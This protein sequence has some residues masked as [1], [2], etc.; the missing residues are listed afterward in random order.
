MIGTW[1]M[2]GEKMICRI[3]HG[4]TKPENADTYENLLKKEIFPEIA[5]KNVSGYRGIYLLRREIT[6]EVEFITIM[7][8]DS[9]EAVKQFAGEDY[10][11]SYVPDKARLVLSR[12]DD[13]SQ[14]YE[15]KESI[16][17]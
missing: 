12:H 17:Y 2:K 7:H 6:N 10:E 5:S 11:N 13:R 3:W 14:H 1:K 15:I 4:W 9:L 8:F 16:V